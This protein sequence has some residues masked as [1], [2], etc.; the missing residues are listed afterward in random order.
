MFTLKSVI[1]SKLFSIIFLFFV[2]TSF[3]GF[4]QN[5]SATL[6]VEK[7]RNVRSVDE[8][9]TS[10]NLELK[11]TSSTRLTY[12]IS[13]INRKESCA[14]KINYSSESNV[15]LEVTIIGDGTNLQN[16]NKVTINA[17]QSYNFKVQINVPVGTPYYRW[18]CI[19][20]QVKSDKC[21]SISD[22]QLLKVYV[23]NPSEE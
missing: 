10:F 4:S 5:C 11:N 17:G 3:N 18:S 21:N 1:S 14:T 15:N 6:N 16:Y 8:T 7:Q 19:E 13:T 22:S 12:T 2:F 23:T 20:V 9:G